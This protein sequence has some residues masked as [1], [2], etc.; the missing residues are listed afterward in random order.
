MHFTFAHTHT[1][2]YNTRH[3][4][5]TPSPRVLLSPVQVPPL[6][7]LPRAWQACQ[8]WPTR[9]KHLPTEDKQCW[10]T[11][12]QTDRHSHKQTT[13]LNVHAGSESV[14]LLVRTSSSLLVLVQGSMEGQLLT[15][16]LVNVI[17][18]HIDGP[19]KP[20]EGMGWG[21]VCSTQ[22][23]TVHLP[24]VAIA[25]WRPLHPHQTLQ[26]MCLST[27]LSPLPHPHGC[28]HTHTHTHTHNSLI[29]LF[30]EI[31]Q[32]FDLCTL[33]LGLP[34]TLYMHVVIATTNFHTQTNKH[35]N[36][37]QLQYQVL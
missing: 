34:L 23:R 10:L 35:K 37:K 1:C 3:P 30:N 2:T 4:P 26:I 17:L 19:F 14:R 21:G 9:Q 11:D 22:P 20:A 25:H 12:R 5:H 8:K 32:T 29:L 16:Q 7:L 31:F 28:T 13:A 36:K 15:L 24:T 6:H 33:S 18:H 27:T